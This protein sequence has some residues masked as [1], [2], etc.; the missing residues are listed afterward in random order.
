VVNA[1]KGLGH[2]ERVELPE[3]SVS[4][5]SRSIVALGFLL[6]PQNLPIQFID[7]SV[8]RGIQITVRF[9][10]MD[11]RTIHLHRG[12]CFLRQFLDRQN[13]MNVDHVLEMP[14]D[15]LEFLGDVVPQS[16]GQFDVMARDT[17]L[18][19]CFPYLSSD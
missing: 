12:L 17:D 3:V 5:A 16:V 14:F 11:F 13:H 6:V 8:D 15:F 19:G 18:H 9:S 7:Q 4:I 1:L 2:Q 10:G